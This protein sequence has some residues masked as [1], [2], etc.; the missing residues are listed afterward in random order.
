MELSPGNWPG[1]SR[2]GTNRTVP[3]SN[4][5]ASWIGRPKMGETSRWRFPG[6]VAGRFEAEDFDRAS[7][8]VRAEAT[9]PTADHPSGSP[10]F[11]DQL[12]AGAEA[13]G[14]DVAG[15]QED[16]P[17]SG[18]RTGIR[19]G[20]S[21]PPTNAPSSTPG[22]C[23]AGNRLPARAS[24]VPFFGEPRRQTFRFMNCRIC[25]AGLI[26]ESRMQTSSRF[27]HVPGC[28]I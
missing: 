27:A 25:S 22:P 14:I 9:T 20:S 11:A 18:H 1:S 3:K 2:W 23:A 10:H 8:T 12:E 19:I 4:C 5:A 16:L 13:P 6:S 28:S 26:H 24:A 7:R 21:C 15:V 17:R